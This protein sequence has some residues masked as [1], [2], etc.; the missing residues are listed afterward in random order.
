MVGEW[1]SRTATT[2]SVETT[3]PTAARQARVERCLQAR[4]EADI[5]DARVDLFVQGAAREA[6]RERAAFLRAEAK[7]AE[8]AVLGETDPAPP[9]AWRMNAMHKALPGTPASATTLGA[10]LAGTG[11]PRRARPRFESDVRAVGGPVGGGNG[12]GPPTAQNDAERRVQ[13]Y[14]DAV[15]LDIRAHITR[16]ATRYLNA[17][18]A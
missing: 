10:T 6:A 14:V 7:Q 12:G 16:A 8:V 3:N 17:T 1:R 9:R 2:R 13:R 11:A 4:R 18:L 15:G 5:A